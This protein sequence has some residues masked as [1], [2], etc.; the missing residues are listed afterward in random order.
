MA[1]H[2]CPYV[3]AFWVCIRMTSEEVSVGRE[4]LQRFAGHGRYSEAS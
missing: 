3:Y 4:A 2:L 1:M